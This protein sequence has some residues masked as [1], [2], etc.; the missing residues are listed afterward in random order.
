MKKVVVAVLAC[1]AFASCSVSEKERHGLDARFESKRFG[2]EVRYPSTA[3]PGDCADLLPVVARE[4]GHGIDFV[5]AEH[6]DDSCAHYK[7]DVIAT[8]YIQ[9]ARNDDDIRRF[10][11]RVFSP[12]CR[13][14]N[15]GPRGAG[16][17]QETF[18]HL[19]PEFPPTDDPDFLCDFAV[20]NPVAGIVYYSSLMSK[21]GGAY[22]WPARET[23]EL[24]EGRIEQGYDFLIMESI[25]A[26]HP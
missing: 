2:I 1:T 15:G 3:F 25:K 7:D 6:P 24:P 8:I 22:E 10:V 14:E 19:Q 21:N 18:I 12:R 16:T 9:K 17:G 26:L 11:D 4:G 20:V 5:F 13:I 23:I